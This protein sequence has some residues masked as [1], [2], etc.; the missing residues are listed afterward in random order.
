MD[1]DKY[2]QLYHKYMF[3]LIIA[4]I[5]YIAIFKLLPALLPFI[6][7]AILAI[8]ID[9]I[10]E[11]LEHKLKI[12]RG[13]AAA[14][15]MLSLFGL[16]L[17]IIAIATTQIIAELQKLLWILPQYFN[18]A[19]KDINTIIAQI[20][21]LYANLPKNI[22]N[23]IQNNIGNIV[24]TLYGMS[25]AA[26]NY[27]INLFSNIPHMF[28]ISMITLIATFFMSKDKNIIVPFLLKQIPKNWADNSHSIK[29]D[30]FKTLFGFLRA[31]LTIMLLTF[32]ECSVGLLIIGFDYAFLIGLAVSI[33]DALPI[34]GS[35][36]VLVPW[37]LILI[38]VYHN[39][40]IGIYLLILYA[41]IIILRQLLEP[42]IV[43]TSIGL[44]PLATL[45]SMYLGLYFMGFIGLF[46]GPALVIIIKT[47]QKSGLIPPFRT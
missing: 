22:T 29:T 16:I 38:F 26:I 10:I 24:N 41:I 9:P 2:A 39:V 44:H 6:I 25:K 33:V 18:T 46:L 35:G 13:L 32:I 1:K 4:F 23:I 14:I 3:Y 37:A 17:L 8:I 15:T 12:P 30:L 5:I 31:E 42:H 19:N 34:L 27:L 40:K 20:E 43:G 28:M 21:N 11:F 7:A 36:S 47:V 45:L